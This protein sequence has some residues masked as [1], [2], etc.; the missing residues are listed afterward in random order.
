M[1]LYLCVYLF[2]TI[3]VAYFFRFFFI[4]KKLNC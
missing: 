4:I 1:L 3:F 2:S